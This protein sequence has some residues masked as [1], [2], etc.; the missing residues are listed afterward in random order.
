MVVVDKCR[1]NY[2]NLSVCKGEA[3]NIIKKFLS[4]TFAIMMFLSIYPSNQ[5]E[6]NA[7]EMVNISYLQDMYPH[8]TY[9]NGGNSETYTTTPCS[10]HRNCSWTGS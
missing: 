6:A 7:S 9:W 2:Y 1:K 4:V 5:I 10:S 8:G 3:M